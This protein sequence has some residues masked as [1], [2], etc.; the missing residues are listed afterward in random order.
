MAD[1]IVNKEGK[2]KRKPLGQRLIEGGFITKEQ[3]NLALKEQE[4][5]GAMLG[6][7]LINLGFITPDVLSTTLAAQ[8][9]VEFIDLKRTAIEEEAI[10][11]VP[12]DICKKYNVIP[13]D[14][15]EEKN[16]LTV[17]AENIFDVDAI[18]EI[19]EISGAR[20]RFVSAVPDEITN[21]IE[22]YYRGGRS[23]DELIEE[24]I[25]LASR[26]GIMAQELTLA[27]E[28]PIVRLVDQLIIKGIKDRA[29]D[30]HIEPDEKVLRIRYRIDGIMQMGPTI[31]KAIQPPVIA[32]LK[33]LSDVNIA[34]ARIPM[35]GRVKFR[36]GKKVID[37]RS[38]FYPTIFGYNVV[39]RLLDKSRVV[40]GLENLG[41]NEKNLEKFKDVIRRPHG[42]VLVTGPTGSG[43]TTTLYSALAFL[44]SIEK[45]I[46][47]I[48]DPIEYEFPIIRQ[49]QV[50]EKAG[51]T[52]ATGL[53]SILRQDPDIIMVGEMRDRETI[54]MAIRAALT[55][56]LVF[57][58]LH[59]ND[60][61]S[62]IPRLLDMGVERF[63]LAS[64]INA[65]IAQR[66]VR[67]I[68]EN[69]KVEYTPD[70]LI[71]KRVGWVGEERPKF[72]KG[73][74]CPA[75]NNTGYKG[76]IAIF[77]MLVITPRLRELISSGA[78][79]T[80]IKNAAL[81][82]GLVTLFEDGMEK[83]REGK[84]TLEEVVRVSYGEV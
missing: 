7:T 24:S 81:E 78:N 71:L 57:S 10:K 55:G 52:F 43:K 47:T 69:C 45:N 76:R 70:P 26:P 46:I 13:I 16:V 68:C 11:K 50:N 64:T 33:I 19:E 63:L 40:L 21:A 14:Y 54:D 56:H 42:I 80:E 84:T 17:A 58:T 49:S 83:A 39:L 34:E 31:P 48:E 53:R 75:C 65:I 41:F 51:F 67:T 3:L 28:A 6:E 22:I 77:E 59:T 27:E 73:A 15:D 72:Y 8:S 60:A 29:T 35:D 74:G 25:N 1:D 82:E 20:V 37:I 61:V 9:G 2:K 4:R 32:R 30:I 18:S 62:A 12:E 5:T 23:L 36:I 79:F 38:S 66:L 44:N